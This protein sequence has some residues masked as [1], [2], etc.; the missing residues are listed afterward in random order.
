MILPQS[1][2]YHCGINV[3]D[4]SPTDSNQTWGSTSP[5][6]WSPCQMKSITVVMALSW[7]PPRFTVNDKMRVN[8]L[9][10]LNIKTHIAKPPALASVSVN[11]DFRLYTDPVLLTG[12]STMTV[13]SSLSCRDTGKE[14]ECTAGTW[15]INGYDSILGL[16]VKN[17][18]L[19]E[20]KIHTTHTWSLHSLWHINHSSPFHLCHDTETQICRKDADFS[21]T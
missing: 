5:F 13:P 18:C 19:R 21:I 9:C 15:F 14:L 6:T 17:D 7:Q 2:P 12:A 10:D 1:Y 20:H 4:L 11:T 8:I 3:K 16:H